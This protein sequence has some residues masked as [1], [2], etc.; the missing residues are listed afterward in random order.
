MSTL[1]EPVAIP[2]SEELTPGS[3]PS[4]NTYPHNSWLSP[5]C[6]DLQS[7]FE[8]LG[9]EKERLGSNFLDSSSL[10]KQSVVRLYLS[11]HSPALT[12][13][14]LS[15]GTPTM[16]PGVEHLVQRIYGVR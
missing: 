14:P 1:S 8:P 9:I 5:F 7:G 3:H 2:F 10:S 12:L 11:S 15:F 4:E 13:E 16:E 6:V